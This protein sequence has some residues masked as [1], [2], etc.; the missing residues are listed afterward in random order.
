MDD[1]VYDGNGKHGEDEDKVEQ[2]LFLTRHPSLPTPPSAEGKIMFWDK[3]FKRKVK[4][5]VAS[6]VDTI[7]E[8]WKHH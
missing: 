4:N 8:I 2:L 6:I 5:K 7:S 3:I 1:K